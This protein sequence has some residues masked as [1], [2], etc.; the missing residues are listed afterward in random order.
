MNPPAPSDS[1]SELPCIAAAD[2]SEWFAQ[3][4]QPHDGK[5]RAYLRGS[6]PKMRDVD[7]VIQESYLRM[8][9]RQAAAPIKSAKAF[10]FTVARRLAIDWIRHEK[11]SAA[12]PVEDFETLAVYNN[13]SSVADTVSR[14]EIITMLIDAIDALP[15]RCREIVIL[16]KLKYCSTRET[17]QQLG[18]T[19]RAVETQLMRGNARIRE[20]LAVRGVRT[21]L[22]HES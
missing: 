4:V 7:D 20:H 12:E 1:V 3:E 18:I 10:L 9:R 21:V 22:G 19:E 6:F 11:I 8:W 14:A 5:L 2:Q 17:A 15:P 13:G 16:R